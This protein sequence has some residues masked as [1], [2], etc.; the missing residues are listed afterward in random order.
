MDGPTFLLLYAGLLTATLIGTRWFNRWRDARKHEPLPP[1]PTPADPFELAYLRGGA[2]ETIRL[3]VYDLMQRGLLIAREPA[4]HY[5]RLHKRELQAQATDV[6]G[7]PPLARIVL[8]TCVEPKDPK[9]L[10]RGELPQ[11]VDEAC[12]HWRTQHEEAGFLLDTPRRVQAWFL[13]LL[14]T[15]GLVIFSV[16]RIQ[17]SLAHGHTNIIFLVLLTALAAVLVPALGRPPARLTARGSR[18][19][20]RLR[21]A[22]APDPTSTSLKKKP[23]IEVATSDSDSPRPTCSNND[24]TAPNTAPPC[25]SPAHAAALVPI[26]LYGMTAMPEHE[27]E[28]MG[29]LFPQAATTSTSSGCGSSS[30]CGSASDSGGDSGGAS[31]CGGGGC[32]GGGD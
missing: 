24:S 17:D 2:T 20:E 28:T 7:L 30:S 9:D 21:L 25:W 11:R 26:S 6:P 31:G 32:G 1:I 4:H 29:T 5:N 16:L 8:R 13:A 18:Q 27:R 3:A 19:L 15:A 23:D 22:L 12:Q 14:I 10:M